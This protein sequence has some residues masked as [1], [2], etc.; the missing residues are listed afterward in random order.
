MWA[1]IP[2]SQAAQLRNLTINIPGNEDHYLVGL[3]VFHQLHCLDNVRKALWPDRYKPEDHMGGQNMSLLSPKHVDHCLDQLRQS[4]QCQSDLSTNWLFW[5][6]DFESNMAARDVEHSCRSFDS[7]LDW[8]KEHK[9]KPFD[10]SIK[11]ED[12]LKTELAKG[13]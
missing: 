2:R 5:D 1:K 13:E 3:D 7:V 9:Q 6:P 8:A 10:L 12:P 4:I 11:L